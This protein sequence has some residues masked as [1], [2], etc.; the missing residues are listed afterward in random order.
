MSAENFE[1]AKNTFSLDK[2]NWMLITDCLKMKLKNNILNLLNYYFLMKQE[3]M[4]E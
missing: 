3:Q 4:H 2:K 1:L